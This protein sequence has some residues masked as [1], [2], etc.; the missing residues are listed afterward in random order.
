MAE[1]LLIMTDFRN[2]PAPLY[3]KGLHPCLR[4]GFHSSFLLLFSS[5]TLLLEAAILKT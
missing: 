4:R 3:G 5:Y 2:G 1:V